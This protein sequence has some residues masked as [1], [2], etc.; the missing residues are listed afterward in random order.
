MSTIQRQS[1]PMVLRMAHAIAAYIGFGDDVATTAPA[2]IA[3]AKAPVATPVR[4]TAPKLRVVTNKPQA[5][6]R[7]H[8]KLEKLRRHPQLREYQ[9]S[10]PMDVRAARHEAV[11]GLCAARAGAMD[12]ARRHFAIAAQCKQVDLTAVPG[13][14]NLTRGQMQVAVDAYE[15]IGRYRDGAALDAHIATIFRPS[16]V[17]TTPLPIAPRENRDKAAS[18]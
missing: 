2:P 13:F 17:G 16:L 12:V 11:R 14:W 10:L 8:P 5:E 3:K 1:E 9:P 15:Q 6:S 18:T 4:R 7:T